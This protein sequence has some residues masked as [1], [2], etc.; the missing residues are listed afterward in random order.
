VLHFEVF[1][2]EFA[3]VDALATDAG[4]VSEVSALDHEVRNHAVEFA[5]FVV[6]RFVWGFAISWNKR[7]YVSLAGEEGGDQTFLS[8]AESTEVFSSSWNYN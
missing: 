1:I 7:E 2:I 3:S 4:A 5:S 8:G 6:K